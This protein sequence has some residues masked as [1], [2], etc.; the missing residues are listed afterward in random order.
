MPF[1]PDPQAA[2][3]LTMGDSDLIRPLPAGS[4]GERRGEAGFT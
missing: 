1:V 3:H 4:A 2:R